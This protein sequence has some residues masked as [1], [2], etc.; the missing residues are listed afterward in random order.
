MINRRFVSKILLAVSFMTL[1][2]FATG[3]HAD[4]IQR[5][6]LPDGSTLLTDRSCSS[7][8]SKP[9]NY[10]RATSRLAT[11]DAK[12]LC[13]NKT[14][15]SEAFE[16]CKDMLACEATH[17]MDKCAIYCSPSIQGKDLF[18]TSDLEFG[19]TS[20]ACLTMNKLNRGQNWIEVLGSE[21]NPHEKYTTVKYKCLDKN[22]RENLQSHVAYCKQG[23]QQCSEVTTGKNANFDKELDAIASKICDIH[24]N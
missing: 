14:A 7:S 10:V 23:A 19:L 1:S 5:C 21:F 17:D 11:P 3:A 4:D 2:Y 16:V 9:E 12:L 6:I 18:P 8:N 22:G 24:K 15:K 20:P 13:K